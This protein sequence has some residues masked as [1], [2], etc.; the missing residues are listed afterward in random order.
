[1]QVVIVG[2]GNVAT[3]FGKRIKA[4]GY[5]IVQVLSRT[6]DHAKE[7]GEILD[8]PYTND[9]AAV[10]RDADV[11]LLAVSDS[12]LYGLEQLSPIG[13]KLVI[14]TAGSVPMDVL[15]RVT[16]NYGVMY[17][18]QSLRKEMDAIEDIPLLISGNNEANTAVIRSIAKKISGQVSVAGDDER[19]KLHVAAVVV[20]NFTNHLYALAEDFCEKEKVDFKMLLPLIKETAYRVTEHSPKDLQTGPAFR[21]DIFT[22][23]KHLRSLSAYPRLKYVYLKLTDS[24]LNR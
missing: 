15:E 13:T 24:I 1:M 11:Y 21:N 16:I 2:S 3:V 4:A 23:D 17:P 9:N 14:H 5:N 7:L 12:V 18:L 22:L 20:S 10:N 19:L 6:L 8:C